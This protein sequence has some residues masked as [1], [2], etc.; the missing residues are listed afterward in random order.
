MNNEI[1]GRK[2]SSVSDLKEKRLINIMTKEET[3]DL[4]KHLISFAHEKGSIMIT[5]MK[6][7][8]GKDICN[9]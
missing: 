6:A 7:Q 3:E 2:F 1:T 9:T 4:T 8:T 5:K